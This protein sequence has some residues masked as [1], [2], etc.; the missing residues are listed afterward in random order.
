MT[1]EAA[2]AKRE[3]RVRARAALAAVTPED[4][5]R[6]SDALCARLTR[7]APW[8]GAHTILAF[9]PLPGEPDICPALRDAIAAG[10]RICLPRIDWRTGILT[11]ALVESI[12]TGLVAVRHG[13]REPGPAA[14]AVGDRE[15]DLALVPGLAFDLA[16][17]RLGRGGGFYDRLLSRLAPLSVATVGVAFEVQLIPEVPASESDAP[18]RALVTER[19]FI[20]LA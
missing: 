18:V 6:W 1:H 12:D 15:L 10:R 7:S 17:R 2:G 14:P 11:P 16:G 4:A 3:A 20:P 9:A 5:R 19:R 8:R 13:V